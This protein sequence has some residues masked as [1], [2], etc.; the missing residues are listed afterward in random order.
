MKE[1]SQTLNKEGIQNKLQLQQ[2]IIIF[3]CFILVLKPFT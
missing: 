2:H 3:S 1:R